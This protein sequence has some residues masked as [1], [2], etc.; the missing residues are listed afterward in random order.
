[1]ISISN[2]TKYFGDQTLFSDVSLQMTPGN[3]YGVVG[4]NGS[5]KSTFLR[6]LAGDEIASDGLV[7][8]PKRSRVGV[9]RQDHFQYENDSIIHVAMMGNAEVWE[10]MA[11]KERILAAPEF[12]ADRYSEVEDTIL[13]HDGYTLEAG[14]GEILEG[15]GIPSVEHPLP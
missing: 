14:A 9:L 13:R 3:C 4:A 11:E 7:A 1:M 6:I 15:L 8:I 12:D 2:L 10:A 5:G